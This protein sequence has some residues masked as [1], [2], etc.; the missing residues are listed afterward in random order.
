MEPGGSKLINYPVAFLLWIFLS[1]YWSIRTCLTVAGELKDEIESSRIEHLLHMLHL[2]WFKNL[3]PIE[4]YENRFFL[5]ERRCHA[6]YF[7]PSPRQGIITRKLHAWKKTDELDH[8]LQAFKNLKKAGLPTAEVLEVF[9]KGGKREFTDDISI[10]D[11]HI[12]EDFFVKPLNGYGAFG[13][14]RWTYNPDNNTYS[15]GTRSVLPNQLWQLLADEADQLMTDSTD[16]QARMLQNLI[17]NH[18]DLQGLSRK[19]LNTIRVVSFYFP[20]GRHEILYAA[21]KMG[22]GDEIQDTI[23]TTVSRVDLETGRMHAS[24][25]GPG[26]P[27][28]RII[29]QPGIQS[30]E[31][32]SLAGRK[33]WN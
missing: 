20:S 15:D 9:Y 7:L 26:K 10:L 16:K 28:T 6:E 21:V 5:P 22:T 30:R 17:P 8:K 18:P 32:L 27:A 1:T 31:L 24:T 29:P 3:S 4:F 23:N 13:V 14:A 12:G 19:S 33:S 2:A 11:Q 25:A